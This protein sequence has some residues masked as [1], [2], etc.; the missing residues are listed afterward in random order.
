MAAVR[1]VLPS[2]PSAGDIAVRKVFSV[3]AET[4]VAAAKERLNHLRI[5]ALPVRGGQGRCGRNGEPAN[6]RHG[7]GTPAG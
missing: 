5:N 1:D 4:T 3:D 7:P 2:P 6:P